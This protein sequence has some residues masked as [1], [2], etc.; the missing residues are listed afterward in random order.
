MPHDCPSP[1]CKVTNVADGKLAC[2]THWWMLPE[3]LRHALNVAYASGRGR[4]TPAHR[5]AMA[6]CVRWLKDNT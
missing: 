1:E 5:K 4:F 3:P 6:E 2:R